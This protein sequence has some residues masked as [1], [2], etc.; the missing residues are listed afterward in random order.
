MNKLLN[1]RGT[2][3]SG[4]TTIVRGLLGENYETVFIELYTPKY[5][6]TFKIPLNVSAEGIVAVGKYTAI[7]CGGCDTIK[8]QD[9]IRASVDEALKIGPTV[10]EGILVS[11]I[12]EKWK[13]FG[14]PRNMTYG[15]I[16]VPLDECLRRVQIRNGGKELK[17]DGQSIKD[18]FTSIERVRN[19]FLNDGLPVFDFVP[20]EELA[21]AREI[22]L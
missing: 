12:Y 11:H 19:K 17:N 9:L 7:G 14:E 1:I 4:K 15:F 6:R 13:L 21:Q 2:N 22:L 5:D 8:T 10:F 16:R 18:K 20:G 3:G